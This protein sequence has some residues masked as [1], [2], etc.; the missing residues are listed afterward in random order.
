MGGFFKMEINK[1]YLDSNT[2][3][4]MKKKFKDE[5]TIKLDN[6]LNCNFEDFFLEIKKIKTKKKYSPEIFRNTEIILDRKFLSSYKILKFLKSKKFLSFIEKIVNLNLKIKKI[7]CKKYSHR[8]FLILNDRNLN[9][10]NSFEIIFDLTK[11]W[12][13]KFGGFIC[14]AQKRKEIFLYFSFI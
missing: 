2:L 12:D 6:F 13:E 14:Y 8:D 4:E 10:K 1:I 5:Q 11:S 7:S 3:N 9:K